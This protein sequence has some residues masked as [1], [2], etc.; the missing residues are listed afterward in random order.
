[1]CISK[2][3]KQYILHR[4]RDPE[5]LT[6]HERLNCIS[7][8]YGID[9]FTSSLEDLSKRCPPLL[10]VE[11]FKCS[12]RLGGL[13]VKYAGS[14][15]PE[16]GGRGER[17]W[18]GIRAYQ[19]AKKDHLDALPSAVPHDSAQEHRLKRLFIHISKLT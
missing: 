3:K 12:M 9:C 15:L 1:M 16:K 19:C 8:Q 2:N 5:E 14:N 17:C 7:T 10:G 11:A 13:H 6:G 18:N 4:Q